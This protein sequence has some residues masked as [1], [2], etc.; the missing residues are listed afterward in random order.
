[1]MNKY[2]SDKELLQIYGIAHPD[3][4]LA[5]KGS[6]IR[7]LNKMRRVDKSVYDK[8][9]WIILGVMGLLFAIAM[10]LLGDKLRFLPI[11]MS[12]V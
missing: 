1:M 2:L 3:E 10:L 7:A 11:M 8:T 5:T 12:L 4:S 6:Q 9:F